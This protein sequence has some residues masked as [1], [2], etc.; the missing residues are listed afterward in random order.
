MN[1]KT[2]FIENQLWSY[3][4]PL[5]EIKPNSRKET[6]KKDTVA[7]TCIQGSIHKNIY[8]SFSLDAADAADTSVALFVSLFPCRDFR[9][10]LFFGERL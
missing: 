3:I 9:F 2:A 5:I 8:S 10:E 7:V 1:N 4:L 6:E